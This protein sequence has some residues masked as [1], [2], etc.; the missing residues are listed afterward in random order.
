ME[1]HTKLDGKA[2]VE[3][4][5]IQRLDDAGMVR[6]KGMTVAKFDE[7][8]AKLCAD[9]A[10]LSVESLISLAEYGISIGKGPFHHVWP[11]E[12]SL[13]A[14]GFRL[15]KRPVFEHAI[16]HSWLASVEGPH[17]LAG[18]FEVEL[19]RSLQDTPIPPAPFRLREI[20][21]EATANARKVSIIEERIERGTVTVE[22]RAWLETYLRDR[23]QVRDIIEAGVQKRDAALSAQEDAA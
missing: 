16:V 19:F 20:R 3:A 7:V 12:A 22:D 8:R 6:P 2:Q 10:Y 13:R 18:G 15:E 5:L 23:Q 14:F 21:D 9:F 17:A 1:D 4:L 11:P